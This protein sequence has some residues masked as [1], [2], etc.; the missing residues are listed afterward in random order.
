MATAPLAPRR[1]LLFAS[2]SLGLLTLACAPGKSEIPS[3]DDPWSAPDLMD[4]VLVIGAS[5][6]A[7]F[8]LEVDLGDVL[9]A[10]CELGEGQ[11]ENLA[12][13]MFFQDPRGKGPRMV[14]EGLSFEPTLVVALDFPFWFSYGYRPE[15]ERT[16]FLREGLDLLARFDVPVIVGGI[17]DM[18]EAVGL[19]LAEDQVPEEDIQLALDQQVRTWA[20]ELAHVRF[21][22]LRAGHQAVLEGESTALGVPWPPDDEDPLLGDELHPSAAGLVGMALNALDDCGLRSWIRGTPAE[23]FDRLAS[24]D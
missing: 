2:F 11:V 21:F 18:S 12:D 19:M 4:R 6:S 1:R 24:G 22:D 23:V 3:E 13:S 8:L 15:E 9:V 10:A 17:P 14:E 16:A 5:A 20:G 7:G